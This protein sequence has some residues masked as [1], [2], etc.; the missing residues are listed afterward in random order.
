MHKTV[1]HK[2]DIPRTNTHMY[3]KSKVYRSSPVQKNASKKIL[4][5]LC[6]ILEILVTFP[7]A[8]SS[9]ADP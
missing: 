5:L 7:V 6:L 9:V 8:M 4:Q 1:Q 2:V 3:W